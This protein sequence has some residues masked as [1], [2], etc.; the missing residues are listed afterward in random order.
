[1]LGSFNKKINSRPQSTN[2]FNQTTLRNENFGPITPGGVGLGSQSLFPSV[3]YAPVSGPAPAVYGPES[4]N[5]E[6]PAPYDWNG[7]SGLVSRFNNVAP[8]GTDT[9]GYTYYKGTDYIMCEGRACDT[10]ADCCDKYS[11]IMGMCQL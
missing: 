6:G 2:R 1:M 4:P 7:T 11:C 10:N 8:P 5:W 9:T 3:E